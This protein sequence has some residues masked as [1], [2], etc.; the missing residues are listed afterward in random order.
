MTEVLQLL[1]AYIGDHPSLAVLIVFLVSAGEAMLVIGL[2]VPSTVVLVGAGTLVGMGSLSFAPIF[3]ATMMG[4]IVGDAVSFWVGHIWKEQIREIWPFKRYTSLLD[5]GEAFFL[6]HGNKSIFIG[7]FIPGVKAFIPGVAGIVGMDPIRFTVINVVSAVAWTAVHLLPAIGIGRGINVAHSSNPRILVLLA[8]AIL[9]A[10]LAWYG[11]KLIFGV[12]FPL[13]ERWRTDLA[14]RLSALDTDSGIWAARLLTNEGGILVSFTYAAI[15]LFALSGFVALAANLLFDPELARSDAAISGYLQTLRTDVVDRAMIVI[16]MLGDG[17]VM[18]AMALS[19]VVTFLL[20]RRWRLAL[21]V[22]M[23]FLTASLFVPV[24]KSF[25]HRA[26]PTA[27]YD[28]VEAFSFPSGHA[29]LSTAIL[30]ITILLLV[31]PLS[32]PVRRMAYLTT[33]ILIALIALSRVYLLAHWP[34]DVLA[35]V[36][37]GGSLVFAMAFLLHGRDLRLPFSRLVGIV[38]ATVLIIYPAHLYAGFTTASKQYAHTATPITLDR[39]QWIETEWRQL[40]SSRILLDGDPG[41]PIL[42]QTD[43][44]LADVLEAL[45]T[46]GWQRQSNSRLDELIGSVLP[47]KGQLSDYS[48]RPLTNNGRSPVATMVQPSEVPGNSRIVLRV[49]ESGFVAKGGDDESPILLLSVTEEKLDPILFGFSLVEEVPS[50]ETEM[51]KIAF[52]IASALPARSPLE[53]TGKEI[54]WIILRSR[55]QG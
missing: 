22:A 26:R 11:A 42:V 51:E 31:H 50:K 6:K 36:L 43:L 2:F 41:E 20:L 13:A 44:P 4:A 40:P 38:G 29:T 9:C 10:A 55:Q 17:I 39:Q 34:S 5:K 16:T 48:P 19:L 32:D 54:P 3:L 52:D 7:R 25:L 53:T 45:S 35:G 24:M 33:A 30:G 28:G 23:A 15:V 47:A 46:S 21:S 1:V 27:L 49:W 12:L 37:F 8:I 18:L 14:R